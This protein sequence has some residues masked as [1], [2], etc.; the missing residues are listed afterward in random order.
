[1]PQLDDLPGFCSVS[2]MTRPADGTTV[3]AVAYDSWADLERAA[4]GSR[5]FREEFG[6]SLG[7]EVLDTAEFDLALAHLQVP[8][9]I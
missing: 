2:I 1:M 6:P 8:E 9:T 3:A 5:V 4:E 7:I